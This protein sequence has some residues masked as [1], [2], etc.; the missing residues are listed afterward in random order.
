MASRKAIF[1]CV[2]A[3]RPTLRAPLGP[4]LLLVR[5]RNRGSFGAMPRSHAAV[6]SVDPSS[7]TMISSTRLVCAATDAKASAMKPSTL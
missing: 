7:I 1:V 5:T 4:N 6:P 2:A 3:L